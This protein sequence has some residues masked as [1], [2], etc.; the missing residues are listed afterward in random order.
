MAQAGRKP[1]PHV[2]KLLH[3]TADRK[4]APKDIPQPPLGI[5]PPPKHLDKVAAQQW[6]LMAAKLADARM[7]ANVDEE[8]LAMYCENFALYLKALAQLRRHGPVAVNRWGAP[9]LSPWYTVSHRCQ[10]RMQSLLVEFGMTPSSRARVKVTGA[11]PPGKKGGR[12]L[13]ALNGGL[14]DEDPSAA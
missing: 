6:H 14:D 12:L 4:Q 13:S 10:L 8:A 11:P 7:V 5:G 9:I 1:K 3:G 2:L